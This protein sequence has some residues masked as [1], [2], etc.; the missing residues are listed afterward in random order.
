MAAQSNLVLADGQAAPV[1]KTFTAN[2]F[3]PDAVA[4]W[5]DKSA[6]IAIGFPSITIGFRESA[7]KT[8]IEKR[9]TLPTLEVISGSDAGYTPSP[10][11][12]YNVFTKEQFVLPARC[13]VQNRKDILAFSKNLNG[14]ATMQSYVH[15]LERVW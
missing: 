5:K 7:A 2:G 4:S 11:V 6:G 13:T 1:N 3:T 12:A 10:K 15:D 14:H 8:E 9:I